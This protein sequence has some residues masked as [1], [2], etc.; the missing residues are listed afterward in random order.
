MPA[1]LLLYLK[2][3]F[4]NDLALESLD[5]PGTAG[6][7]ESCSGQGVGRVTCGERSTSARCAQLAR[8]A[9]VARCAQLAPGWPGTLAGS[10]LLGVY[11]QRTCE[12]TLPEGLKALASQDS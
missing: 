1:S 8:C 6:V 3:E 7:P 12:F 9:Q 4:G 5:T 11:G 2:R 10:L